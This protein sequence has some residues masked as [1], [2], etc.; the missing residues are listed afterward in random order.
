MKQH[1][2]IIFKIKTYNIHLKSGYTKNK[3]K[4]FIKMAVTTKTAMDL[5][6]YKRST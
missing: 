4:H 5:I 3:N 6:C 2:N 1:V